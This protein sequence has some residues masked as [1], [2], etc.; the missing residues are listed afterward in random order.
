MYERY[1]ADLMADH[2]EINDTDENSWP[3]LKNL[4][5]Y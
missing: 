3:R 1:Q 5:S 4:L 2:I